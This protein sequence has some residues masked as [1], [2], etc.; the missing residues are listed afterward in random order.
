[1]GD[2]WPTVVLGAELLPNPQ[3][4]NTYLVRLEIQHP[5]AVRLPEIGEHPARLLPESPGG[6]E[7]PTA[8]LIRAWLDEHGS[9]GQHIDVPV[10][11]R[12]IRAFTEATPSLTFELSNDEYGTATITIRGVDSAPSWFRERGGIQLGA[13]VG[14]I[15]AGR[16][17]G[18]LA[19][20]FVHLPLLDMRS[21]LRIRLELGVPVG[22]ETIAGEAR[23]PITLQSPEVTGRNIA[24]RIS[25]APSLGYGT[26][27]GRTGFAG[28]VN[29]ELGTR[30]SGVDLGLG[31]SV[32]ASPH[33]GVTGTFM[34]RAAWVFE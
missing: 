7:G 20:P 21:M 5:R 4:P 14:G 3:D 31:G 32:L 26:Y 13:D 29:F 12:I 18:F 25:I 2:L 8:E 22:P 19:R 28:G 9:E 33:P 23:L 30:I 34:L 24:P 10:D 15:V 6:D 17:T 1:M 11:H 16:R 27:L